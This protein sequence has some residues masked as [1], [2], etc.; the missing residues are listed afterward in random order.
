MTYKISPA[1]SASYNEHGYV[2][3]RKLLDDSETKALAD[4][5]RADRDIE[6]QATKRSDAAGGTTILAVRDQLGDDIYSQIAS[7][8]RIVDAMTE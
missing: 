5:A 1:D 7:S 6:Q 4:N 8:H 3:V 2:I